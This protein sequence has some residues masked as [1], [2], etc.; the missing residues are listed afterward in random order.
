MI[1]KMEVPPTIENDIPI[2]P[3]I[4]WIALTK[5]QNTG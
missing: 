2:F 3:M 4:K 1:K 5:K